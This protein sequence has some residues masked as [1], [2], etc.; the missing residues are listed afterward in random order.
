MKI[1]ECA[2]EENRGDQEQLQGEGPVE[3]PENQRSAPQVHPSDVSRD[4]VSSAAQ[5]EQGETYPSH[6][7]KAQPGPVD[8]VGGNAPMLGSPDNRDQ[9]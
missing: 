2:E 4:Q 1:V 3:W 8:Q 7:T 5:K 9:D 6:H